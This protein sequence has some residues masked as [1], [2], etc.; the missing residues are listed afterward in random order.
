MNNSY[1]INNAIKFSPA[2]NKL[3][4][5]NGTADAIT[6]NHPASLCFLELIRK[7]GEIIT[8]Q[9][10]MNEIWHKNGKYVTANTYY[11]NICLLRKCLKK[12]G[13]DENTIVTVPRKGLML[14]RSVEIKILPVASADPLNHMEGRLAACSQP[15]P[16]VG[17]APTE[18]ASPGIK[19]AAEQAF[20]DSP[21][22]KPCA[23]IQGTQ[24]KKA[25]LK[26]PHAGWKRYKTSF[27]FTLSF[28][29]DF[30]I[31]IKVF[32]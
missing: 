24:R 4:F 9:D 2:D 22:V 26:F 8:Q 1:V 7:Q 25:M 11:Q 23:L 12:T 27:L 15:E 14:P 17:T 29:F 28:F 30:I 6:L 31:T 18:V 5:L 32:P 20:S 16:T 3:F 13:L 21:G 19:P 10:F